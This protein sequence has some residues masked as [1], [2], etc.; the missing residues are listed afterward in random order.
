MTERLKLLT[1]V[2]APDPPT[3]LVVVGTTGGGK[4]A[5]LYKLHLGEVV[6]TIPTI[7]FNV[8]YLTIMGIE[9]VVWDV[10][11]NWGARSH[12]HQFAQGA[13]GIIC[14]V[15]STDKRHIQDTK[16]CLWRMYDHHDAHKSECPLL[17][18][19]NKQDCLGALPVAE[20]KDKME[21]DTRSH[22]RRWH[23]RGSIAKTGD[24]LM[25]GMVWMATQI[26]GTPK[27]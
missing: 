1:T 8:E 20:V 14:V 5:L 10:A 23:I 9:F 19:A 15:D 13:A 11:G 27:K 25:E 18:F 6:S 2:T 21:L 3:K 24:G 4:T 26:K 22:D 17:V 16:E 7:N 12:W